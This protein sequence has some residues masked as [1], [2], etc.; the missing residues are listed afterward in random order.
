MTFDHVT[1]DHFLPVIFM[2]LM[3]FAM[4]VYV[5]L[6]GYDLGVGLLLPRA[7]DDEKDMMISSIGPFWDA[8]ETWLV[9]GVGI[10]LIAFPKAYGVV[11]TALYLPVTAMLCGLILR[12]VA[13]EFRV[14]GKAH[15]KQLWNHAFF[16]GSL[17]ASMAQGWMLG[18]YITGLAP[19][20]AFLVF[21]ALVALALPAAYVLLGASWLILKT[22]GALQI[23]ALHWARMAW[24]AVAVGMLLISLATPW[25]SVTVRER[26]FTLPAF[27]V[28][29]PIPLSTVAA[30]FELA[31]CLRGE[32]SAS[33]ASHIP[34]MLS[35]YIMMMGFFGLAYSI[36][37]FVVMDRITLWQAAAAPASLKFILVGVAVTVPMIGAYTIFAYRTFSGKATKLHYG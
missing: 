10:L 6:D 31:F 28:L 25:V 14:K 22:E 20:T 2:S 26:W 16:G 4:L 29:L 11:L 18:R 37:P 1:L 17:L 35:A 8:N 24:P 36:Y 19:D 12:G 23:K 30:L 3:G 9:L 27:F 33:H 34:I 15:H 32:R 21:A 13:F 7:S 5:I